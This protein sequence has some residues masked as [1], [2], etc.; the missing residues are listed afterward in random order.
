MHTYGTALI[1]SDCIEVV[2]GPLDASKWYGDHFIGLRIAR[3][4]SNGLTTLNAM[5]TRGSHYA[6]NS[7]L[8][9]SEL[10]VTNA[11][12]TL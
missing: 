12:T 3:K 2:H 5:N 9:S 10:S 6:S 7:S 4:I 11:R 8:S 1:R